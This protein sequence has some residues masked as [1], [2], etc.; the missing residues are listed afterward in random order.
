M[1]VSN[2]STDRKFDEKL[3]TSV[4]APKEP[5]AEVVQ[6]AREILNGDHFKLDAEVNEFLR[7]NVTRCHLYEQSLRNGENYSHNFC[8]FYSRVCIF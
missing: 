6:K 7:E 2:S 3:Q 1:E 4:Q 8:I 5:C